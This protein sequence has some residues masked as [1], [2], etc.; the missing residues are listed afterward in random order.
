LLQRGRKRLEEEH[1][2]QRAWA[3][4]LL[5]RDPSGWYPSRLLL[6]SHGRSIE[7]GPWLVEDERLELAE[8]LTRL[9]GAAT[10]IKPAQPRPVT[11]PCTRSVI[12]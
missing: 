8:E 6:R 11:T 4:I 10:T 2:F 5:L 1:R 9:T 12:V 3:R 7:I